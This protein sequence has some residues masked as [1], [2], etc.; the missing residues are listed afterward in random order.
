MASNHHKPEEVVAKLGQVEVQL[1]Q[2]VKSFNGK[3]RHELHSWPTRLGSRVARPCAT[4]P[5]FNPA[6][7]GI[8]AHL[9]AND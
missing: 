7:S 3:M 8:A 4:P 6:W 5:P 1:A 9:P 2:G